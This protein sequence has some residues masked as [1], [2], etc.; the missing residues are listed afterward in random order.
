MIAEGIS[1]VSDFP[2]GPYPDDVL[3]RRSANDVAFETPANK[4]GMGTDSSLR[5]SG[6][7]IMGE[8][9]IAGE[10]VLVLDV[11]LPARLRW[12]SPIIFN[13]ARHN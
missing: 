8:A 10:G 4:D 5:K 6:D 7:P 12:L 2:F 9:F 1:P 11:R 13:A 3:T